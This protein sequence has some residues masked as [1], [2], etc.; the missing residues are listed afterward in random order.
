VDPTTVEADAE[1]EQACGM[2]PMM[3]GEA[4]DEVPA[5]TRRWWRWRG[6]KVGTRREPSDG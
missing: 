1:K 2:D 5:W 6:I 3:V 4:I